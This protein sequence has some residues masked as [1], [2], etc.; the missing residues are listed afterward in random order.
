MSIQPNAIQ[1]QCLFEVLRFRLPQQWKARF[2]DILPGGE[3]IVIFEQG[4]NLKWRYWYTIHSGGEF[5]EKQF[6][7]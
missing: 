4:T 2:I 1:L 3:L 5:L 6:Y 7:V